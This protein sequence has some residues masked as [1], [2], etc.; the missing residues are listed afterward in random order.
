MPARRWPGTA[1]DY[2][3]S[4]SGGWCCVACSSTWR[5]L[6]VFARS[7]SILVVLPAAMASIPVATE[8]D[9]RFIK[10]CACQRRPKDAIVVATPQLPGG[11][12]PT[13]QLKAIE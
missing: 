12:S 9:Y 3:G 6:A 7:A 1:S 5:T 10:W 11:S 2:G 8:E 4:F 13:L